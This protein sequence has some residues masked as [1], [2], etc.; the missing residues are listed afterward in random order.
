L[1]EAGGESQ[2]RRRPA[3]QFKRVTRSST[4]TEVF[5]SLGRHEPF[6]E[7]DVTAVEEP[8]NAGASP[9]ASTQ[10]FAR[11]GSAR[12]GCS[13]PSTFDRHRR[14]ASYVKSSERQ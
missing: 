5:D 14:R 12:I 6:F 3:A 4:L 1:I 2:P 8:L 13:L 11:T 10:I 9:T 7:A